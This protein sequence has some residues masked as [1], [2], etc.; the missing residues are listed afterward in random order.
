MSPKSVFSYSL[1]LPVQELQDHSS[2]GPPESEI[3]LMKM[4]HREHLPKPHLILMQEKA[5]EVKG[6]KWQSAVNARARTSVY[7]QNI[8]MVNYYK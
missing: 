6:V 2:L 8:W 7:I 5:E 3:H 4:N 1:N